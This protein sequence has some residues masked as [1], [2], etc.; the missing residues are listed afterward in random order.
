MSTENDKKYFSNKIQD[1]GALEHSTFT[2]GLFKDHFWYPQAL[3]V[4]PFVNAKK[5]ESLPIKDIQADVQ[6]V[7]ST[8]SVLNRLDSKLMELNDLSILQNKSTHSKLALRHNQSDISK[9]SE[10]MHE[11]DKKQKA[12]VFN[13]KKFKLSA[14]FQDYLQSVNESWRVEEIPGIRFFADKIDVLFYGLSEFDTKDA[15]STPLP[16]MSLVQSDQDLLGKMIKSINLAEGSFLRCPT[17]KGHQSLDHILNVISYFKPKMVVTL[18]AAATN[19]FLD[20][21]IRLSNVHGEVQMRNFQLEDKANPLSVNIF[22]LF[23]P[24]L[25]EINMSMKK[26]A[27]ID[28][29][30]L[31]TFLTE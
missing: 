7:Q 17:F 16:P 19:I 30:R 14:N 11:D 8:L 15:S 24:D 13:S 12:Q 2:Y 1:T 5:P 27:W 23:H 4:R 22:P 20:N 28:L 3:G 26:T 31:K 10:K 9:V 29:Q 6:K 21:R 25:L 18:G